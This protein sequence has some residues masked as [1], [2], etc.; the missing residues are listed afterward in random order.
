MNLFVSF[1][2]QGYEGFDGY[3]GFPGPRVSFH[4]F[5]NKVYR[6]AQ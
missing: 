2:K 5:F 4:H 6:C 1:S 3:A